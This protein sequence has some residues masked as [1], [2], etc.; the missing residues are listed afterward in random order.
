MSKSSND[1]PPAVSETVVMPRVTIGALTIT[2]Q[3]DIGGATVAFE[4]MVDATIDRDDLNEVLDFEM[5]AINRQRARVTL[6]EK[7]L[8]REIAMD[9]LESWE[10][11]RDRALKAKATEHAQLQASFQAAN[12]VSTRRA[13]GITD[14]QRQRLADS[15]AN[16]E[17]TRTQ[18]D[19]RKAKLEQDVRLV[20]KQIRR[21]RDLIAGRDP[22]DETEEPLPLAAE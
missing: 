12:A 6:S 2:I 17:T 4:R 18:F 5:A 21:L 20:D 14:Q 1:N 15:Q 13:G 7:L 8:A 3:Q 22:V 9:M 10:D 11:D 19:D 16:I